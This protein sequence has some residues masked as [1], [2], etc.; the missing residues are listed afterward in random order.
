MKRLWPLLLGTLLLG[1]CGTPASTPAPPLSGVTPVGQPWTLTF[2]GLGTTDFDV[3]LKTVI[4]KQALTDRQGTVVPVRVL[5]RGSIDVIP[6]G[7]ARTAGFR[8]V[9]SV[10][11]V[12]STAALNNVSFLGVRT[13][14][15]LPS[16]TNDTAISALIR[17][18]GAPAYTASEAG[19]LA[20]NTQPAQASTFNPT[21]GALQVLPNTDDTV[22]YL[23]ES[24]LYTP[25]GM[26][27]L[28]PYG[29]T[30]LNTSTLGRTL[31]TGAEAN[32]MVI[33]MKVPLQATAQDDPYA[34]SFTAI[35]VSDSET[36]V[37]Q[38]LEGLLS[39]NDAAVQERAAAV[40]GTLTVLSGSALPGTL[41]L[42]SV[43]TAGPAD[44]ATRTIQA[45]GPHEPL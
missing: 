1:A 35:P 23:P 33:G 42:P 26:L 9:Y 45:P 25:A 28:L 29:F 31:A 6:S 34:F 17:A 8:Y 20:L 38:S 27:G 37:T 10:V 36:R 5:S 39:G 16:G 3:T 4:N 19:T 14:G 40:G 13:A 18:P 2:T 7:Q 43:R 15:T 44:A 24:D 11:S 32:R 30:V 12:T 22:Q 41:V 21:T